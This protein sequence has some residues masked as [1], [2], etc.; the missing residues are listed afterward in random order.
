MQEGSAR[1]ARGEP[2]GAPRPA[3]RPMEPLRAE[4]PA[5]P[6]AGFGTGR[7]VWLFRHA[8]VAEDWQ[9]RIYGA[10]D[11]PL[12]RA[13]RRAS[14]ELARAFRA[15]SFEHVLSSSLVRAATL[16]RLL[17]R[18][19]GATL[20]TTPALREIERGRW[21]GR[22]AAEIQRDA[23]EEIAA[24]FER[25]WTYDGYGGESDGALCARAWPA[26]EAA[27]TSGARGPLAVVAHYNVIR[28]LVGRAL[29]IPPPSSFRLRVDLARAT[30]LQDGA[31]GWSLARANVRAPEAI[32]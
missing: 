11:V 7:D 26:F 4:P 25:S 24:F 14:R 3:A 21:I 6:H 23:P 22:T 2:S 10:L 17:A 29:G 20:A 8:E 16:A 28:V 12:S 5:L 9:G 30:L 15:L 18:A 27:V 31:A 19:T 13:G 1:S 32:D